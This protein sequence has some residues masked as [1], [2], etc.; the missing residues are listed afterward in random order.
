MLIFI[1]AIDKNTAMSIKS[2]KS[3]KKWN[4]R[5][6]VFRYACTLAFALNVILLAVAFLGCYNDLAVKSFLCLFVTTPLC[7]G[8]NMGNGDGGSILPWWYNF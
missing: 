1:F 8:L 6:N 5:M 7:V 2:D 4:A 3:R